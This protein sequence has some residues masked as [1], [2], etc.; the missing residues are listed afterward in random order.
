MFIFNSL[1]S[2]S[3]K[4][5]AD[6]ALKVYLPGGMLVKEIIRRLPMLTQVLLK[7]SRIYLNWILPG[8][9]KPS[10][11]ISKEKFLSAEFRMMSWLPEGSA[12]LLL[13]ARSA[14]T[15]LMKKPV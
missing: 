2:H 14:R 8:E 10:P 7:F 5:L 3:P 13:T 9:V 15:L 11:S 4:E 6:F 1:S 12:I